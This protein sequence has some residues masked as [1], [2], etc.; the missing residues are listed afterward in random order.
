MIIR[1]KNIYIK[2]KFF[3]KNVKIFMLIF[4]KNNVDEKVKD[5]NIMCFKNFVNYLIFDFV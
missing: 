1:L 4:E 5:I 2:Q 3:K